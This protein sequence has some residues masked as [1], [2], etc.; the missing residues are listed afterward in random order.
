MQFS[1]QSSLP[2]TQM[3]H[4]NTPDKIYIFCYVSGQAIYKPKLLYSTGEINRLVNCLLEIVCACLC[5]LIVQYLHVSV[6]LVISLF[7]V[8]CTSLL[9]A[10]KLDGRTINTE[11]NPY[12]YINVADIETLNSTRTYVACMYVSVCITCMSELCLNFCINGHFGLLLVLK[13]LQ[14]TKRHLER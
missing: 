13:I 9:T 10:H 12:F 2:C 4:S 3:I 8:Y 11:H 6:M 1:V 5:L 7:I 14:L